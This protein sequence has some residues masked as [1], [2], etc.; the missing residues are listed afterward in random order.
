[1]MPSGAPFLVTGA[2]GNVGRHVLAALRARGAPVRVALHH[3]DRC[4]AAADGTEAVHLDFRDPATYGKALAGVRGVFL[5]RPNP[6]LDVRRTLNRFLDAAASRNVAH[7]VFLSVAGAEHN[8]FV[9]HHKVEQHLMRGGMRWTMLRPGFFAQNLTGPYRRDITAGVLTLPAA[10]ARVAYVDAADLGELAAL[11]LSRPEAH[12][13]KG[14]HLTGPD[15]LTFAEVAQLLSL[16]LGRTVR[17]RAVSPWRYWMH[18]REQGVGAGPAL[19]YTLIHVTLRNG[20]G[21]TTSPLLAQLL[22]RPARTMREF[23]A[24]HR[25]AWAETSASPQSLSQAMR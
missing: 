22:G 14:Y 20:S 25:G 8:S 24:A 2:T 16:E 10:G 17:Y 5:M 1:M 9:P 21:A 6:V 15:S 12:G 18:C 11:A 23:I 3:P 7:V 13:G 19:A 4:A